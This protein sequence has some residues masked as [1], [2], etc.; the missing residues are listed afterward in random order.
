[1]S[2]DFPTPDTRLRIAAPAVADATRILTPAALAFLEDVCTR[3]MPERKR[4]LAARVGR[5]ERINAGELPDLLLI[6]T[7]SRSPS[8]GVI[9]SKTVPSTVSAL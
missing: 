6:S 8:S 7:T 3:F 9:L 5:Q 1:M 4:L 2:K